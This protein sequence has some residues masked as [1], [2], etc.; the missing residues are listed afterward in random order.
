MVRIAAKILLSV[1]FIAMIVA[2]ATLRRHNV[3]GKKVTDVGAIAEI[4][5]GI[6]LS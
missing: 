1:I 3:S 4:V 6:C 5:N 2:G